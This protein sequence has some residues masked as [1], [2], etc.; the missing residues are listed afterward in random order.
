VDQSSKPPVYF[1][2]TI[3]TRREGADHHIGRM[4][5]KAD[6]REEAIQGLQDVLSGKISMRDVPKYGL[7]LRKNTTISG[8]ITMRSGADS[9]SG[10]TGPMTIHQ[11]NCKVMEPDKICTCGASERQEQLNKEIK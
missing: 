6:T 9:G 8:Q 11:S 5:V 7:D 1:E 4:I 3:E 2:L 10:N